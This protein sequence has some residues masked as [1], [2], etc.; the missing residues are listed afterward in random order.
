MND[1]T[2]KISRAK[3][4]MLLRRLKER[5]APK[6][7]LLYVS[8]FL[9]WL[10][11]LMRLMSF[12]LI[13]KQFTAF[14]AGQ[15]LQLTRL[16]VILLILN[17]VG[18]GLAMIA[19]QLQGL[20]SQFARDSLK[21][22]FFDAFIA[23][24]G[25]FDQQSTV[26]DVLTVASQGIDSLDTY[27]SY[28]L[29]LAMR[30]AFNCT[31]VLLLVFLI[32]PIGGLVFILSLPLIPISIVAMQKRSK[33]IMNHY[34][35]TYMDVGNLFMDDL[36]GLNTLYSYQADKRYE[37]SFV[38][39]A[40]AFRRATMQLLGFQLQAVGY[41]DA[42][43]YLG[44]GLSGFLAVQA[45]SAGGISFFDFLFF[46]LIATEFFAP[47]REQGYGMH[48]VMMN[49]KMADQIFGFLDSVEAV[50][51]G[52]GVALPAFDRIDIQ[53]L[54][55][56]HGE[57]ALL[58]DITMTIKKGELTAV[59]GVS[60]QGKTSLAQL[61]LKRYQADS[62]QIF[63]GDVAIDLASKQAINQEILYV[64]DQ[65]TLLNMSI[66]EN[67]AIA[68]QLTRKELLSWID[69]HGILS[70]IYWLPDGIDTI[71]GENGCH[72]SAGQRQQVICARALLSQRSCYIFDEATSSLDAENEAAIHRLLQQLA[73]KAIVIVITHKM[74][75]LKQADQV[76]F[77]SPEQSASLAS[78]RELYRHHL[79][80]RQLVDTQ[81]E[82]EANLYG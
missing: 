55:F 24:D 45:L 53:D 1:T 80:Y 54:S 48:L 5:I 69:E 13:A 46:I 29:S 70:F 49:T 39:K 37:E 79:A 12:Y 71:V 17:A 56:S 82:L 43:M 67:L 4:K 64:S 7:F 19:K 73:K 36:K 47:I 63:L 27:Y 16:L 81:A 59:A 6:R 10:Q 40:E 22:S 25:Q 9:S 28:Y 34:W 26:A 68:T 33:R 15:A 65:S 72:L 61:L 52:K 57:K 18:F 35:S 11:F 32:Y 77:L 75:Y 30:T 58:R 21:Q 38:A 23:M 3:K 14:L 31:T 76:L 62:G 2:E 66:Y 78:P 51:Q 42:V 74:K 20:A 41:M 50:D 60:G 44:I 8:A